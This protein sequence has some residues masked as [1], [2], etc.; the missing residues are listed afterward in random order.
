MAVLAALAVLAA[1]QATTLRLAAA[2][3][4]VGTLVLEVSVGIPRTAAAQRLPVAVAVAVALAVT[5]CLPPS[6]SGL[7]AAAVAALGRMALAQL[8][9]AGRIKAPQAQPR[10]SK[11]AAALLAPG[12]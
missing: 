6:A 3:A 5:A 10:K 12:A 9:L 7:L 11:V 1:S 8:A 4:L 2:A